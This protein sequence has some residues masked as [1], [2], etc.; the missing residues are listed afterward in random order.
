MCRLVAALEPITTDHYRALV[1]AYGVNQALIYSR[2]TR[3][4]KCKV[5]GLGTGAPY[6]AIVCYVTVFENSKYMYF[7][8]SLDSIPKNRPDHG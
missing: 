3:K 7:L 1:Q 2:D 6:C 5:W 8:A 4:S